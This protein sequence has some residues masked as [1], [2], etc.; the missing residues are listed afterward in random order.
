MVGGGGK[1]GEGLRRGLKT[2]RRWSAKC[3]CHAHRETM[4]AETRWR[5]KWGQECAWWLLWS[6]V[7]G[8]FQPSQRLRSVRNPHCP[9][10]QQHGPVAQ[11]GQ[12]GQA[13]HTGLGN[14]APSESNLSGAAGEASCVSPTTSR[15]HRR[16]ACRYYET[17]EAHAEWMACSA[18]TPCTV[19][20][21]LS[22]P[23]LVR[24]TRFH[25]TAPRHACLPAP[26]YHRFGEHH[27]WRL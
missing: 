22:A 20:N 27:H 12:T 21:R 14:L 17:A 24:P 25:P 10:C 11:A 18:N 8:D 9:V 2:A 19:T 26:G 4:R 23:K 16:T 5:C 1:R 6:L 3:T 13:G 15:I 7:S